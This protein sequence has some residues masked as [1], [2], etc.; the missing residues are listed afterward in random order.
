MSWPVTPRHPPPLPLPSSCWWEVQRSYCAPSCLLKIVR[1][2]A[3]HTCGT[4]TAHTL[5]I[6]CSCAAHTL[7]TYTAHIWHIRCTY[8]AHTLHIY[9]TYAAHICYTYAA[10]T[11]HIR[12]TYA[13]HM[14]H[15]IYAGINAHIRYKSIIYTIWSRNLHEIEWDLKT[16]DSF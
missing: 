12:C 10:H 1:S 7:H 9:C 16:N 8:A 4:Y 14:L 13:T 11:L 15:C 3:L 2:H 5:H 6:R